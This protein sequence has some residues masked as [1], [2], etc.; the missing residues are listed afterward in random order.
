MAE[1]KVVCVTMQRILSTKVSKDE[2]LR[3]ATSHR[4]RYGHEVNYFETTEVEEKPTGKELL[5]DEVEKAVKFEISM[6]EEE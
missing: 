6:D 2:A 3:L 5:N 1:Y 4:R